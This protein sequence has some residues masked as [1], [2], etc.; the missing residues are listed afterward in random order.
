MQITEGKDY[1]ETKS[2]YLWNQQNLYHFTDST[3]CSNEQ[4]VLR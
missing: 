2:H 1:S 3:V 4:S